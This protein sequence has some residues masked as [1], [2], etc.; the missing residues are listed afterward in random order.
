M[1]IFSE[2]CRI[3]ALDGEAKFW[4]TLYVSF[5]IMARIG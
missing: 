5:A 4:I 3:S 2:A 1:A